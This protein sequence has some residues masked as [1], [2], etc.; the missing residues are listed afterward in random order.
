MECP[1][2]G[3]RASRVVHT[4]RNEFSRRRFRRCTDCGTGY[5]TSEMYDNDGLLFAGASP[6]DLKRASATEKHT[7]RILDPEQVQT[8]RKKAALG[9]STDALAY[10]FEVSKE[11]VREVVRGRYWANAPS[12]A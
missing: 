5:R 8:L 6:L 4:D 11:H 3:S 1:Y 12:A 9:A 2:C 10:D 7:N